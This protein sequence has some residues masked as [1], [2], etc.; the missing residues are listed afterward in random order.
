MDALSKFNLAGKVAIVTGGAG[1]LGRQFCAGLTEAGA[2]V[3]VV[4]LQ[5]ADAEATAAA[6]GEK[7]SGFECDVAD[8]Q[9]VAACVDAIVAR[10]GRIDILH[11]N[12]ATK[13]ADVRAFFTP[14]EEYRLETWKEVMSVNI[15][16][17]FL[18]AQAVGRQMIRQSEGGSIIQTASI[19][20]LVG[21]DSRIY[22]GSDYLGGPINTPA[23]YAASK[24]AVVGLT[25]W[26]ATHWAKSGIRVNCLVPGGV[27]SGQN[28]VFSDLYSSR[29]PLGR[30]AKSDE[31]V[32]ALLYLASDA[33]SYVTG[34]V[35]AVDGGWTCW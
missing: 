5:Q 31:M 8:A 17:M 28:S 12:A 35:L 4:D 2:H 3:A 13:T 29:V 33:S 14:F 24:S 16:G 34:Q 23:V 27:S 1:I 22:E 6:L 25:R 11:N 20:G 19:Y 32:P 15:D 10:F 9:A 18:M 26:L 30:M 21:P 7:A